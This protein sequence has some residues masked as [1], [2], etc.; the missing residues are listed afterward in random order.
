MSLRMAA[1]IVG[2]FAL[3]S[4]LL[5]ASEA[6]PLQ[7]PPASA[8]APSV[9]ATDV[10]AFMDGVMADQLRT[11]HIAGAVVAVVAGGRIILLKGYGYSDIAAHRPVD[12]RTTLFRPGSVSK[13]FTFTAVMQLVEQGKLDLDADV[14]TYLTAFKI[15]D[16]Y[17]EPITLRHLITH[18]AGFENINVELFAPDAAHLLSL[19]GA[20]QRN[21]PRRVRPPGVYSSY[22][23]YGVALA[24]LIVEEVSGQSFDEYVEEHIFRPL[25]MS[26][27]TFREPLPP[28]LAPQM[29][30]AYVFSGGTFVPLDFEY[31]HDAAPAGSA[32]MTAEDMSHFM[33]AHLHGGQYGTARILEEDT[34]HRM[35][36]QLFS[37]DGR[38]P[39]IAYG[40][41]EGSINGR[42]FLAHRG[43]TQWFHSDLHLLIDRDVGLFVS[44]NSPLPGNQREALI[45]A[46]M[47]RYFPVEAP[48]AIVPPV[49]FAERAS[50]YVGEYQNMN[51]SYTTFEK[52]DEFFGGSRRTIS[53]TPENTLFLD[54]GYASMQFVEVAPDRF[55]QV[56]GQEEMVFRQDGSRTVF[57]LS[58]WPSTT[59][60]R[61]SQWTN[62]RLQEW[63]LAGA[64]A[65]FGAFLLSLYRTR[66]A[67]K[68]YPRQQRWMRA[69]LGAASVLYIVFCSTYIP[70]YLS[71]QGAIALYGPS[72]TMRLL[73]LIPV[74]AAILTA[75]G[76]ALLAVSW[77]QGR[78][79]VR[80]KVQYTAGTAAA[81]FMIWFTQ[82]YNLFGLRG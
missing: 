8:S 19:A 66:E 49:D 15:P 34:A 20:L 38:V 57:F 21:Q 61:L 4:S 68:G 31:L 51:R 44:Y 37:N 76:A 3:H 58:S 80:L 33:I 41:N 26:H 54:A 67:A 30:T 59:V 74:A 45:Q 6:V 14:N 27:S 55:R 36:Q 22:S 71:Q 11:A 35:H 48:D 10:E 16:T 13:L 60:E 2:L 70:Y 29:S 7:A 12:A 79:V 5:S 75:A 73:L 56:G 24:G 32:T 42:R 25:D 47:D 78:L 23:N 28:A 43:D 65:L 39:G 81:L 40:F 82:H 9:D 77:V 53:L 1:A 18:T 69:S 64:M 72:M 63:L 17:P 62:P 46:F 52:F 50:R